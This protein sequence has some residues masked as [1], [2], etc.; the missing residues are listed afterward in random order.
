MIKFIALAFLLALT[1]VGPATAANCIPDDYALDVRPDPVGTPTIISL[2]LAITDLMAIDDLTQTVTLDSLVTIAWRDQR[3]ADTKGCR[4]NLA[5]VWHPQ[6]Q[7]VNS[8]DLR[9]SQELELSVEAG[10]W[11]QGNLRVRGSIANPHRMDDFPFDSHD[12]VLDIISLRYAR[13]EVQFEVNEDW[14]LRRESL[15]IPDWD[16][17]QP[18]AHV[19]DFTLP[20]VGRA[21]SLYQ[22]RIPAARLPE[23]YIYKVIL[24]LVMIVLMSWGVFWIDPEQLEPQM[25]LAGT[26]MLTLIAFQFTLNDLLPRVGYFTVLDKFTLISSVL[27]FAALMEAVTSGYMAYHGKIHVAHIIDRI[28]RWAFPLAFLV[29]VAST[30]VF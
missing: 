16:I 6:I 25:A 2:G 26:S 4:F 1:A 5:D 17:G 13:N 19:H 29:V 23:Y 7:L 10:G 28:C 9:S 27:V 8:S 14:T 24:P 18:T 22:F 11:V 3:L 12:I 21:V 15:T 30:L 20:Q